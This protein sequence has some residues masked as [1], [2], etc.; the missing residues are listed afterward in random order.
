MMFEETEKTSKFYHC[1][2]T[3]LNTITVLFLSGEFL[4]LFFVR[5]EREK[6]FNRLYSLMLIQN[7]SFP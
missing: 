7:F 3:Q 6:Y 4:F 1:L 5:N 2:R